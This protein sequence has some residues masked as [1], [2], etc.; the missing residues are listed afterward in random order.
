[1]N[2]LKTSLRP[3]HARPR[4]PDLRLLRGRGDSTRVAELL[5]AN[6][7]REK[8]SVIVYGV[9]WTH[10]TTGVQIIRCAGILQLLLGNMGR[11]G[12]GIMAMR[13]HASIQGSTDVP[14]LYDL[15]P[16]Y[17]PQPTADRRARLARGLH[18]QHEEIVTGYWS[19]FRE[20]IV[21][22]LKAW[23]GE[24]AK[25]GERLPVRL[26]PPARRRLFACWSRSTGC[27]GA[28]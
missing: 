19:N 16:G 17:L 11:P 21:S 20:F 8:T 14:T 23:Y 25:A 27:P 28:R 10:H 26:A 6:S 24:A 13:G 22:L 3:L 18:R 2:L 5:C 9:G 12:G 15:L 4:G 7:G 1:M